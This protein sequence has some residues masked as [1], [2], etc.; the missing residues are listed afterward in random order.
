MVIQIKFR[1]KNLFKKHFFLDIEFIEQFQLIIR[2]AF[3]CFG[4]RWYELSQYDV[5]HYKSDL[6]GLVEINQY[7]HIYFEDNKYYKIETIV[8]KFFET[9]LKCVTHDI[10][11]DNRLKRVCVAIPSDFHTYQRLVLKNCLESIGLENYIIT[12][13]STALAMPFLAKDRSDASRKLI[14][15]FGSGKNVFVFRHELNS[16]KTRNNLVYT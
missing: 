13:K 11:R 14:I 8:S 7:P 2:A 6:F 4:K 16:K 3:H 1:K 12:I 9:I 15:D 10:F 5:D